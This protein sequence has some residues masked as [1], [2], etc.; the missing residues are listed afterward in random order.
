MEGN[1]GFIMH[2]TDAEFSK[3]A[4][5]KLKVLDEKGQVQIVEN[6]G[7]GNPNLRPY[8]LLRPAN[9][10][11]RVGKERSLNQWITLAK[12]EPGGVVDEHY[13]EHDNGIPVFDVSLFVISGRV[14]ITVGNIEETVGANTLIYA[15]S[16]L[17]RS[18]TNVGKGI[19]KFLAIK[20]VPSGKGEKMGEQVY[21]RMPNWCKP[22]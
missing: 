22:K 3:G 17:K 19:A 13:F 5:G 4:R 14:R 11:A 16:N 7:G 15:P 10:A 20:I 1:K 12:L 6:E 2:F 9:V 8:P 18:I 21:S